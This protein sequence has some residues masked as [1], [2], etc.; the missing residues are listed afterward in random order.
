MY[1]IDA[2]R[3]IVIMNFTTNSEN[4]NLL[5]KVRHQLVVLSLISD[6]GLTAMSL[7]DRCGLHVRHS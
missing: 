7:V 6:D 3:K 2:C 4:D 5:Q 1:I